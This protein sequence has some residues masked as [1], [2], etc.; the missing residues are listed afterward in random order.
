MKNLNFFYFIF[1]L[2]IT[3]NNKNISKYSDDKTII[4]RI[5]EQQEISDEFQKSS[6]ALNQFDEFDKKIS[7]VKTEYKLFFKTIDIY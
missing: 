6:E 3:I 7:K 5:N 1:I 4:N 2:I